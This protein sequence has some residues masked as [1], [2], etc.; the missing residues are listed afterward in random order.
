MTR[1]EFVTYKVVH[2]WRQE[3][4]E[5]GFRSAPELLAIHHHEPLLKFVFINDD[6]SFPRLKYIY[7]DYSR[8]WAWLNNA[9]GHRL[10]TYEYGARAAHAAHEQKRLFHELKQNTFKHLKNEKLGKNCI[11]ERR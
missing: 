9:A 10:R 11:F 4:I 5:R 3:L 7:A 1:K 6:E 2:E 8:G